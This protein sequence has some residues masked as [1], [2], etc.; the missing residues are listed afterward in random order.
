MAVIARSIPCEQGNIAN[1]RML[2]NGEAFVVTLMFYMRKIFLALPVVLMAGCGYEGSPLPPLANVP[3]RIAGLTCTQRGARLLIQFSPP[4]LT[5]EG[6]PI[7]PPLELDVRIGPDTE[8][9]EEG[10]WAAGATKLPRGTVTNGAANYEAPVDAWVGQKVMV[11]VR[12]IG[13]NGKSSGWSFGATPIV[14]VPQTPSVVRA[15]NTAEGIRLSWTG[16]E[17]AFRIFRRTGNNPLDPVADVLRPPWTDTATQSGQQYTYAVRA[18][19]KLPEASGAGREAESELS[20]E[21]SLTP[22][23]EFPPAVPS[24]LR[25]AAAP[26]SIELSWSANA[27]ADLAV[28]RVYRGV[29][30][31][32]MRRI[33]EVGVPAYSDTNVEPAKTYRY[34]ISAVDR[35]DNESNRSP[36]VEVQMQ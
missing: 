28:Y 29:A 4:Q 33:A 34:E 10:A 15:E 17:S 11:G 14:P 36:A 6:L 1:C 26:R 32:P 18:I 5:T 9:A 7:K 35:S 25:A 20:A 24:G 22:K 21:V 27:E 30:G 3:G 12:A 8:P 2:N 31:E 19:V 23:D 16:P 13:S